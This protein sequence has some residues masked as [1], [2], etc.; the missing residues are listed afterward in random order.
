[1]DGAVES[2]GKRLSWVR[3]GA[4]GGGVSEAKVS[5]ISLSLSFAMKERG[6]RRTG[7]F[8]FGL[9][10]AQLLSSPSLPSLSSLPF[11]L[12]ARSLPLPLRNPSPNRN[13]P[14]ISTI[15]SLSRRPISEGK[16]TGH[17]RE[18]EEG[19]LERRVS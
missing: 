8:W 5:F 6:G 13:Q 18:G 16:E 11:V 14:S 19:D 17:R 10:R 12:R 4:G 3:L 1:M 15:L 9:S 7:V 2:L